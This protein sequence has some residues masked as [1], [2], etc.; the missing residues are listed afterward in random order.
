MVVN[1]KVMKCAILVLVASV[2]SADVHGA[3]ASTCTPR[4]LHALLTDDYEKNIWRS[5]KSF[6]ILEE[7]CDTAQ[8]AGYYKMYRAQI[9][10]FVG[11]HESALVFADRSASYSRIDVDLPARIRSVHAVDRLASRAADHQVVIVNERHHASTDRLLT[12][13]LL[14]PLSRIGFRFLAIEAAWRGDKINERGFPTANTGYYIND[15][16]FAEVIRA[17]ISLNYEIVAYE[18]EDHQREEQKNMDISFQEA[19]DFFH[20]RNIIQRVLHPYPHARVLI[21]CGYDHVHERKRDGWVPMAYQLK[22]GTGIDPLTIDQVTFS[23]RS[24]PE[25]EHPLRLELDRRGLLLDKAVILLDSNNTP[26]PLDPHVDESVISPRTRYQGGRPTWMDMAGRRR[27]ITV[28][29]PTCIDRTCILEAS[30]ENQPEAVAYDR[31]ELDHQASAVLYL[32]SN[33]HVSLAVFDINKRL[34]DRRNLFIDDPVGEDK[35]SD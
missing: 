14:E 11:N 35:I 16:V 6:R 26:L 5:L 17:A 12:L 25:F 15:V 13:E 2:I 22:K 3:T 7:T 33:T 34:L 9:E 20:A 21:H 1:V 8:S 32:P 27:P 19:R 10:S 18:I 23:E 4:S 24:S 31:M 29:M 30:S 28:N